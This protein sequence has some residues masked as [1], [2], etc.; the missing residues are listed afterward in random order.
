M[1]DSDSNFDLNNFDSKEEEGGTKIMPLS[2]LYENWFLDY[3][4]YVI[5]ERAVPALEDGFKPVQRRLMH[6]MKDLDDGR[7]NKVANIIGHTM[8]YHP[9]GDASIGD[10]LVQ[11]GQKDL[12]IDT[13]GN[14]GNTL[15]GDGAAASRYI[16]ARL[17]KFALEVVFNPK[18]TNWGLSYDGRNKEPMFLPVKF[19]LL[20]A[21]GAEGIAVGLA[22]KILPHNFNELIDASIAVLRGK[23]TNILPDFPNGGMA[24][25]SQYND[26]LRGGRIR[27]R[28]K[29]RQ[30]DTKTLVIEE[31]PH[32][33][34]TSSLIDSIVK[35]N[36]KGKIKIRK[37]E[38]NTAAQA[39]II[40][41]LPPGTSPD[42]TIDALYA[43]TDCEISISPNSCIIENDKP[44]FVGVNEMLAICTRQTLDLLQLELE[45]R[46]NE[47]LEQWHFASLERIFIEKKIYRDIEEATTWSEVLIFIEKGLEPHIQF[48]KRPVTE[49]DIVKLTEIKIKRISKFDS[50]KAEEQLVAIEEELAKVQHNLNN[51]I[52][53]AI[54][55]FKNLK[56]KYGAGRERKTEIKIFDTIVATKVVVANKKLYVDRK[57]G[58]IGYGM[59]KDEYISD[60]SDLDDIIVFH[61]NGTMLV[62][63]ID[64]KK[65]VGKN[66]IHAAVWKK[67][68]KRTVYN[69]IYQDGTTGPAMMKRF[70]VTSITR[71]KE[72]DLTAG[73]K[74]S[75]V[76]YFSAN[77][78]GEAETVLIKLRPRHNLKKQ[79]F[80]LDFA[81]L[82]IKG[83]AAKGNILS[84]NLISKI[85]LKEK[86]TS[87]LAPR[88]IWFDDVVQ[89]LNADGRGTLL[90]S[91]KGADKILTVYQDGYYRLTGFELSTR[92][93]ED[94]VLIRKFDPERP[95]TVVYW[96]GEKQDY[97]VKRFLV[98]ESKKPVRFIN[99][100][101]QTHLEII[102]AAENPQITISFDRRAKDL[103]D[104]QV[105]LA[106]FIA[107]KGLGAIGNRL[108]P[109]KVKN[110]D[111]H[112]EEEEVPQNFEE[113]DAA[114]GG[115]PVDAEN[116]E[117]THR[118][119]LNETE[120]AETENTETQSANSLNETR[121]KTPA[122]SRKSPVRPVDD[123]DTGTQG[124]LF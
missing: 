74:G 119:D 85:E 43:F 107:V 87:T 70:A 5:L 124:T 123:E 50:F 22:C 71:D 45:I 13:Q 92:F 100:H 98:E 28:A 30:L 46:K 12:L 76:L 24:D 60:C 113:T 81:D 18:T 91:F 44:R 69:L 37:I 54:D 21:Q 49:E 31:I 27:L 35:A 75:R 56:K 114:E 115:D 52:D 67:G 6:S 19:P 102:S 47:L 104:E 11:M 93:D 72:Y 109:H 84:K 58:F 64:N 16:E 111:L 94:L 83:R 36:E 23:K 63:K 122:K 17:S 97:K 14:W 88:K 3:A 80:E 39:E 105:A 116:P 101:E 59:K 53:F 62:S 96:D 108:T 68:D 1:S 78:N 112:E 95:L 38:D 66:I 41:H 117:S 29:I 51:I 2:G 61:E 34:T 55:Y 7:Y 25:F 118:E 4:S 73:T 86:G 121:A 89:R 103:E 79:K 8:K 15:T 9:H 65:F 32:G 106:E 40:I 77:P 90:G 42:K 10:A 99:E 26:G 20:L 110:I 33:T 48:L 120:P 57:E 82:A